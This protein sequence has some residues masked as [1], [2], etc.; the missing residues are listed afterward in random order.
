MILPRFIRK[1][2][3]VLRGSVAPAVDLSVR[4]DRILVWHDARLLRTAY[5]ADRHR[6]RPERTHRIVPAIPGAGQGP[7]SCGRAGPLSRRGMGPG[8]SGRSALGPFEH[9]HHRHD[10][11]RPVRAGRRIG[12][13]AHRRRRGRVGAGVFGHQLPPHDGQ[14]RRQVR[15][16]PRLLLQVLGPDPGSASDRQEDQRR[17]EHVRQDQVHPQGG[18][19]PGR[20]GL[21]AGSSRPPIS[22]RI[23]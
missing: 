21:W 6:T 11:F 8:I 12:P 13:R 5:G 23:R 4:V 2:L 10:R 22:C 18:N 20:A 9:P 15:E 14:A 16:V 1:L 3:A 17:Q 19:R 7:G